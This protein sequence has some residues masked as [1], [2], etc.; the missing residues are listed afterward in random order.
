MADETKRFA[1]AGNLNDLWKGAIE[2]F[3]QKAVVEAIQRI[4]RTDDVEGMLHAILDAESNV[5]SYIDTSGR[6]HFCAGATS[7]GDFEAKADMTVGGEVLME[8][9]KVVQGVEG[10]MFYILDAEG[11]ILFEIDKNGSVDFKGIPTDIQTALDALEE[12]VAALEE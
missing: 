1:D 11:H 4:L 12:R 9:C 10:A 2:K 3:A 6:S 7:E 5:L 8:N